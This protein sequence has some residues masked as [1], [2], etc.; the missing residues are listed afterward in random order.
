MLPRLILRS[1]CK[2]IPSLRH[3]IRCSSQNTNN[4]HDNYS[5]RYFPHVALA[6]AAIVVAQNPSDDDNNQESD[7]KFKMD[8][9]SVTDQQKIDY[10]NRIRK[11]ST[12][13]KIFRSFA[14][15]RIKDI[16]AKGL[17]CMTPDDFVRSITPGTFDSSDLVLDSYDNIKEKDLDS[18]LNKQKDPFDRAGLAKPVNNVTG[19]SVRHKSIFDEVTNNGLLSYT[20]YIFMLTVLSTSARHWQILFK[21][22]DEN[23]DGEVDS[24]EFQKVM[25]LAQSTSASGEKNRDVGSQDTRN[26]YKKDSAIVNYFFGNQVDEKTGKPIPKEKAIL[27]LEQFEDF[28]TRLRQ[29]ILRIQFNKQGPNRNDKISMLSL[30]HLLLAY[31]EKPSAGGSELTRCK[32]ILQENGIKAT[33]RSDGVSFTEVEELFN[34]LSCVDDIEMALDMHTSA[35]VELTKKEFT[36]G[37]TGTRSAHNGRSG[38]AQRA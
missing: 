23:G 17:V 19:S 21:V 15:I 10:L 6:S 2:R 26:A 7:E 20:D 8:K 32:K 4:N 30:C 29:D 22:F 28:Y 34:F 14:T 33:K 3:S 27:K 11:L 37:K 31:V 35:D 36:A 38:Q 24:E 16:G 12:P 9:I 25:R 5:F 13:D 18:Y 1:H